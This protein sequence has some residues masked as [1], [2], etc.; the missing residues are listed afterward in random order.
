MSAIF[1]TRRN[2]THTDLAFS[3]GWPTHW[4]G[5]LTHMEAA[6]FE[7]PSCRLAPESVAFSW[8]THPGIGATAIRARHAMHLR[9]VH[10]LKRCYPRV[11]CLGVGCPTLWVGS[12]IHHLDQERSRSPNKGTTE[13]PPK[14]NPPEGRVEKASISRVARPSSGSGVFRARICAPWA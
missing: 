5:F 8:G 10:G 7:D 14:G 12:L 13:P 11:I 6:L 3:G 4:V 1:E 9:I 2:A